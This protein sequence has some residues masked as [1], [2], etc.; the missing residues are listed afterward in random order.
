MWLRLAQTQK[1]AQPKLGVRRLNSERQAT[2]ESRPTQHHR[3]SEGPSQH[4]AARD[5]DGNNLMYDIED[6]VA[7]PHL[8]SNH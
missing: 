6:N 7:L 5:R 3:F 1:N 2:S 4:D 8:A